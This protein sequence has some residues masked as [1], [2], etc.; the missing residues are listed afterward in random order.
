MILYGASGL[1]QRQ[2]AHDLLAKAAE[3]H[4]GLFPLPP[5][6]RGPKGKP[7][8]PGRED[9]TFN[10]SHS[11]SLALCA[12]GGTPVGVD[13]QIVRAWRPGLPRRVCSPR[14]LAWLGEGP[15]FWERFC[16]LWALKESLVKQRG[17]GLTHPISAIQVPLPTG[18]GLLMEQD[19]LWFRTYCGAG[20][21]G[22]ACGLE[23]PPEDIQWMTL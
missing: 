14:E 8:F 22:A 13:I 16:Q 7:F 4:W 15:D 2:Q 12:L 23:Q 17:T 19:G 21:R 3:T 18:E 20:W 5:L 6:E 11:G 1:T 9:L 10:L